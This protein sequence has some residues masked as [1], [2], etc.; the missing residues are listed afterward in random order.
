MKNISE[1]ARSGLRYG[2]NLGYS[3]INR[4]S[5]PLIRFYIS[6]RLAELVKLDGGDYVAV[7]WDSERNIGELRRVQKGYGQKLRRRD[8]KLLFSIAY[9]AHYGLPDITL[10]ELDFK[11][12]ERHEGVI[13]FSFR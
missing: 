1:M 2:A 11:L 5:R 13:R 7:L 3:V 8:R 10:T 6:E 12:D 9:F 4:T